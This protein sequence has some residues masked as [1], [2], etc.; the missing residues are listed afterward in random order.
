M[1]INGIFFDLY[2]TL[3]VYGNMDTAKETIVDGYSI[4]THRKGN[5]SREPMMK[6]KYFYHEHLADYAELKVKGLVSR[7]EL[8]GNPDDF[9]EFSSKN[10]R[11]E[12]ERHGFTVLEQ[13]GEVTENAIC[14]HQGACLAISYNQQDLRNFDNMTHG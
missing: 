8:Y 7:G 10:L 12:L 14:V 6:E 1:A 13:N 2:G 5:H 11:L 4:I 3:L 9:N